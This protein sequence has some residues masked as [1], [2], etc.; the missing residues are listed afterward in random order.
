[1]S[2]K[3]EES[4]SPIAALKSEAARQRWELFH[5][6]IAHAKRSNNAALDNSSTPSTDPD[7]RGADADAKGPILSVV[8]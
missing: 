7:E 6:A 8:R 5:R 4:G 1:M 2:N 3:C